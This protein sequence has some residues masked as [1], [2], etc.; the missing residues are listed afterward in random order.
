MILPIGHHITLHPHLRRR[1]VMSCRLSVLVFTPASLSIGGLPADIRLAAIFSPLSA[2]AALS[3]LPL[4]L[5]KSAAEFGGKLLFVL[6]LCMRDY[7]GVNA[8]M[9]TMGFAL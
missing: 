9:S 4:P 7:A 3:L 1:T 6:H 5:V 8:M 2:S